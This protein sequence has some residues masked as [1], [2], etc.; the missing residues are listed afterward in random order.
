MTGTRFA[1]CLAPLLAA[2][3]SSS[4]SRPAAASSA[5]GQ[6]RVTT[7]SASAPAPARDSLAARML[8]VHNDARDDAGLPRLR[9]NEDLARGAKSWA[10]TLV[11]DGRMRHSPRDAREGIGENLWMGTADFFTLEHMIEVMVEEKSEFR[12]GTFPEVSRTGRWEDVAHY[13][14]IIWPTTEEVG[15][16]LATANGRDALVCRYWPT[17]NVIG[18]PVG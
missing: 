14:Q 6:F 4:D 3:A 15:C 5:P 8:A 1:L 2:C 16:A 12:P 17:G 11:D 10:E 18:R 9:W 13:T 7:A